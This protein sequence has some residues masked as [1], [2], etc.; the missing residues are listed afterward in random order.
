MQIK[1]KCGHVEKINRNIFMVP[2]LK[3]EQN[4]ECAKCAIKKSLSKILAK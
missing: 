3:H 1:R 4:K 2:E